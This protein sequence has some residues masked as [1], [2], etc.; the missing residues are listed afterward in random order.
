[1]GA[2]YPGQPGRPGRLVTEQLLR[3]AGRWGPVP[4][5]NRPREAVPAAVGRGEIGGVAAVETDGRLAPWCRRLDEAAGDRLTAVPVGEAFA[6]AIDTAPN[7][8]ATAVEPTGWRTATLPASAD[9]W[10]V[11][12]Q[13]L[14]DPAVE[15]RVVAELRSLAR[16]HAGL[17]E[18]VDA[19]PSDETA[20]AVAAAVMPSLPIHD[21]VVD[22]EAGT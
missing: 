21:G 10:R 1:M 16:E 19:P 6:E 2:V 11:P 22:T 15:G 8:V 3:A 20:S 13:W 12:S 4:V 18:R 5:D 17:V 9:G 14:F 7:A